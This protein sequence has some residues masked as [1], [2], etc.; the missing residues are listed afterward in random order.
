MSYYWCAAAGSIEDLWLSTKRSW[1]AIRACPIPVV[2]GIGHETDL[3]IADFV[4]DR[5]HPRR[6]PQPSG[7]SRACR[8]LE[9]IPG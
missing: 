7:Q 4:A 6:P 8:L 2:T 5:A 9:G 3:T 1:R